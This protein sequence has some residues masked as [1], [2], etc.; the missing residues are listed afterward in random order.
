[1]D[2]T[3][4]SSCFEDED[5]G[6]FEV[7]TMIPWR[8]RRHIRRENDRIQRRLQKEQSCYDPMAPLPPP[9]PPPYWTFGWLW[10]AE[11]WWYHT[12]LEDR[13]DDTISLDSKDS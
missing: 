10:E 4:I 13:F 11:P 9:E 8:L 2:A 3:A 6:S 12:I 1:M 7:Q 5:C